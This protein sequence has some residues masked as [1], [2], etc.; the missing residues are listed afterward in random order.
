MS[1]SYTTISEM[2]EQLGASEMTIK[3]MV[4]RGDLPP[5]TFGI[6]TAAKKKGWHNIVLE[7][8]AIA[9]AERLDEAIRG[10]CKVSR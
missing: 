8:H 7:K 5:Y 3:R 6:A 9:K 4:G 2:A 1:G 10:A